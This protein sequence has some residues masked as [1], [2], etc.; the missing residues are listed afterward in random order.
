V[1]VGQALAGTWNSWCTVSASEIFS[2]ATQV[3]ARLGASA[4]SNWLNTAVVIN[5][6]YSTVSTPLRSLYLAQAEWI[7]WRKKLGIFI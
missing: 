2:S 6:L 1:V 3:R 5:P 7:L 4:T